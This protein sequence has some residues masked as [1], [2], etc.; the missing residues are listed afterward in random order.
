M[1]TEV[2][3]D[4]RRVSWGAI[5]A[6]TV[7]TIVIGLLLNLLGVGIG[8]ATIDPASD[9]SP[10][11][12]TLGT[13]AAIW[14]L[15]SGVI[16]LFVGGY[17]ASRLS[18]VWE[19]GDGILHGLITWGVASIV[20]VYLVSTT[21]GGIMGGAYGTLS[22]AMGMAGRGVSAAADA[23]PGGAASDVANRVQPWVDQ[24]LAQVAPNATT[25]DITR[26]RQELAGLIPNILQ[27]GQTAEQAA[28]R[29]TEIVSTLAG[30]SPEEAGQRLETAVAAL[31]DQA[32]AA[33]DTAAGAV[34]S[35]AIWSFL[36]LLLGAVATAAGGWVGTR[37]RDELA[38]AVG[39]RHHA[40]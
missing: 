11:A 23:V 31:R 14:W 21:L 27:G 3:M 12:G 38:T 13:A 17:A 40:A 22:T 37:P 19:N 24:F 35:A 18:G 8:L 29:A 30:V 6:G 16:A 1:E 25:E 20:T 28:Q 15:V 39:G 4:P 32:T 36:A 26:A 33:V 7:L 34:S 2:I 9:G 5:V 10:S